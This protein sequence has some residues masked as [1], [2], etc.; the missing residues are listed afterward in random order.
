MRLDPKREDF[1]GSVA[2]EVEIGAPTSVIWLNAMELQVSRARWSPASGPERSLRVVPGGAQFVGF[3]PDAPL[4][5]GSGTLRVDYRGKVNRTEV[6]GVFAQKEEGEWYLFT[7]FEAIAARRGFP[8]F[9]E[10]GFKIP[11]QVTLHVPDGLVALSNTSPVSEKAE[12]GQRTLVFA[13]TRPMPSYLVAVA[14]G[15]STWWTRGRRAVAPLRCASWCRRDE[16]RT[17]PG[18]CRARPSCSR[19]SKSISTGRIRTRSS[20]RS[21]SPASTSPWSIPASSPTARA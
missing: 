9:D 21:R 4:L 17:R 19:S 2:V 8:C 1:E 5:P 20:T 3:V 12:A 7:Q 11:W 13:E 16:G 15:P 14:V 18:R 10:P 6:E